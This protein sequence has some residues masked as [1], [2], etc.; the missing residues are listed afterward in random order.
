[1]LIYPPGVREE[2]EAYIR[3]RD[4]EERKRPDNDPDGDPNN[5]GG[6]NGDP[7]NPYPNNNNN[8]N[9]YR[10]LLDYLQYI[11]TNIRKSEDE[12]AEK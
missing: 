10:N 5:G 1:M 11:Q 3:R 2:V 6:G 8:R 9:P 4:E 12:E 7:I